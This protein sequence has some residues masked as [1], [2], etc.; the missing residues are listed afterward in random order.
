LVKE[1][2]MDL[3]KLFETWWIAR[4]F[5]IL[6]IWSIGII[7]VGIIGSFDLTTR[8]IMITSGSIITIFGIFSIVKHDMK[9]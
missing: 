7:I 6:L 1:R 2:R 5:T 8:I 3:L 9:K 4:I